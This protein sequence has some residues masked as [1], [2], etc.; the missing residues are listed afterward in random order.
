MRPDQRLAAGQPDRLEAVAL[1]AEPGDPRDLLVG[2]HLGAREPVHALRRHA[3]RAAEVAAV[4]DRDPQITDDAPVPVDQ[5]GTAIGTRRD[6]PDSAYGDGT[7]VAPGGG[8]ALAPRRRSD[9][10]QPSDQSSPGCSV[11]PAHA[12]LLLCHAIR[13]LPKLRFARHGDLRFDH[14]VSSLR[15]RGV[16]VIPPS[17]RSLYGSNGPMTQSFANGAVRLLEPGAQKTDTGTQVGLIPGRG[18]HRV[19]DRGVAA[20]LGRGPPPPPTSAPALRAGSPGRSSPASTPS[21]SSSRARPLA[22]AMPESTLL[23]CTPARSHT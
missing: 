17:V 9:H 4:G 14:V 16:V 1:D 19:W 20:G 23:A 10:L 11:A 18:R 3:V 13:N 8:F 2:E 5:R 22:A 6:S 15:S 21:P 7:C 12:P